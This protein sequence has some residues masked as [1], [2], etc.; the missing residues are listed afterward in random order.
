[1]R[2]LPPLV[3]SEK[4]IDTVVERVTETLMVEPQGL[5]SDGK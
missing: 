3:I 4:V 2:F 5:N 1:M